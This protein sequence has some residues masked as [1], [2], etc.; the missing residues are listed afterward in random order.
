[1]MVSVSHN[2]LTCRRHFFFLFSVWVCDVRSE[3]SI[4][5]MNALFLKSELPVRP[6]SV[7]PS[8]A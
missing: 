3:R 5:L 7:G 2:S 8:P 6:I 4:I 1:M